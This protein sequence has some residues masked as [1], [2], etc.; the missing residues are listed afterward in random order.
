[1]ALNVDTDLNYFNLIVPCG[2]ARPVTSIKAIRKDFPPALP[3]VRE[4]LIRH[5]LRAFSS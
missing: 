1:V 3:A 5:T 4:A 2:L